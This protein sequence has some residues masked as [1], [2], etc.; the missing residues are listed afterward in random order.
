MKKLIINESE[1]EIIKLLHESAIKKE[2]R[3][4]ISEANGQSKNDYQACIRQMG[5]PKQI[6][7]SFVLAGQSKWGITGVGSVK[8]YV[9]FVTNK[10]ITP[11]GS[12]FD[13]SCSGNNI[14]INGKTYKVSG[15]GQGFSSYIKQAQKLVGVKDDGVVGQKTLDAIKAKLGVNTPSTPTK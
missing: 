5:P 3:N 9:F 14:I 2:K 8:G 11:S 13:Y 4:L 15:D 12:S 7:G 1:R 6:S 10:G